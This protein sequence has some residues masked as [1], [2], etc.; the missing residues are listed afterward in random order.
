MPNGIVV[1]FLIVYDIYCGPLFGSHIVEVMKV[2]AFI[3]LTAV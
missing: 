1:P 2:N 3:L